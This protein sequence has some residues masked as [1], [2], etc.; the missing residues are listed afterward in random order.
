MNSIPVTPYELEILRFARSAYGFLG[1][2]TCGDLRAELEK[3]YD[4]GVP[5]NAEIARVLLLH[6]HL[7]LSQ[8]P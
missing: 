8:I 6:N 1:G 7:R 2:V 5:Q 4:L 3:T